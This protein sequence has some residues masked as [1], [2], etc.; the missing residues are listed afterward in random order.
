MNKSKK[1][2]TLFKLI[3]E[4]FLKML[5]VYNYLFLVHLGLYLLLTFLSKTIAFPDKAAVLQ[6]MLSIF[7]LVSTFYYYRYKSR[8]SSCIYSLP[9]ARTSII[10]NH[11]IMIF[12]PL[13]VLILTQMLNFGLSSFLGVFVL[14]PVF[15]VLTSLPFYFYFKDGLMALSISAL[16]LLIPV[17]IISAPFYSY[18]D[19]LQRELFLIVTFSAISYILTKGIFSSFKLKKFLFLVVLGLL[20][21]SFFNLNFGS[22]GYISSVKLADSRNHN[23]RE[24]QEKSKKTTSVQEKDEIKNKIERIKIWTKNVKSRFIW[25]ISF[26]LTYLGA[27]FVIILNFKNKRFILKSV[28]TLLMVFSFFIFHGI[29][30]NIQILMDIFD[31]EWQKFYTFTMFDFTPA[32]LIGFLTFLVW[33]NSRIYLQKPAKH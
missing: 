12:I 33:Q 6:I 3:K 29:V 7:C 32:L 4:D 24:L 31:L 28:L 13:L 19:I 2:K 17:L 8:N 14:L 23:I 10:L 30:I 5:P 9:L 20:S 1:I 25:T 21:F 22:M 16:A 27:A 11:L 26:F 15:L 18:E